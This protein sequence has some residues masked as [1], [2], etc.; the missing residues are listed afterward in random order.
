MSFIR[1]L[2]EAGTPEEKQAKS[3]AKTAKSTTRVNKEIEK[4]LR[5][6]RRRR[7]DSHRRQQSRRASS[8]TQ[9]TN[10]R[11]TQM[12][13]G[14][15]RGTS[16]KSENMSWKTVGS[17]TLAEIIGAVVGY[18]LSQVGSAAAGGIKGIGKVAGQTVKTG[19]GLAKTGVRQGTSTVGS[20]LKTP[21]NVISGKT[22][23][24]RAA[25]K[26][27]AEAAKQKGAQA[28]QAQQAQGNGQNA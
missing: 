16:T 27:K 13:K 12:R 10:Q 1:L 25:A 17:T 26:A 24:E 5:I 6:Q 7:S 15:L 21:A 11:L 3:L 14:Q 4:D 28:Q 22:P 23:A 19:A 8:R 9:S 2:R 20:V 18:G